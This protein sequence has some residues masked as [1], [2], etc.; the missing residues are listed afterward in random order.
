MQ[1]DKRKNKAIKILKKEGL[2]NLEYLGQGFEGVVFHDEQYIYKLIL[3]FYH[4]ENKWSF[5]NH[6]NFFFEKSEHRAFYQIEIIETKSGFLIQKYPYEKSEI[7]TKFSEQDCID[8]LTQCW[9]KRIIVQDCKKENFIRVN[10][11]LKLIDMDACVYYN[12]SL[13][14]NTCARMFLFT[15]YY[16]HPDLKKLQRSAI[17]NF[18]LS[19]LN[20]LREFVNRVFANI[21]FEESKSFRKNLKFREKHEL[22]Y[23]EYSFE[24]LPNL[25]TLFYEKIKQGLYLLDIQIDEIFLS[26]KNTFRPKT[27]FLGYKKIISRKEKISLLI[28]TCAMDAATIEENIRHIVRQLSL[29]NNFYEIV[30]SIDSKKENFLRQY[31]DTADYEK[32]IQIAQSLQKEKVIDRYII[33]NPDE[34]ENINER[35]FGIKTRE[36]HSIT[37]VPIASQLYAFEQ[38]KGQY[39][40]QMDSDVM[41]NRKDYEHNYLDDMILEFRKNEKVVSVGFNIYNS[42]T[43]PY[44]GHENGGFVPEVR[45]GLFHKK[46]F[47][48]LRPLPN[49]INNEGKLE[50]TWYRAMEKQQKATGFCSIRGGDN[51]TCYIHP[52]NYRKTMQFAWMNIEDRVEQN[53]IPQCQLNQFDCEGSF[54]EWCNPKRNE[55]IVVLSC[56][57]NITIDKFLRFWVALMSQSYKDFGLILYDDC[58][59]NGISLFIK[60]M[61]EPFKDHVTYIIGRTHLPKIQCEYIAIHNFCENPETIIVSADTDDALIGNDVLFEVYKKYKMW[62]IDLSCGRVHQTYR[63]QSTY[64]YPVNFMTPRSKGG[65]VWQHLKTF[66]KYLF[67]S[68]PIPYFKY[69]RNETKLSEIKWFEK[70]DDFAMMI[71]MVEMSSSPY[72]MDFINYYYDRDYENR[73]AERGIKEDCIAE[74]LKKKK[75]NK[76]NVVKGRKTFHSNLAKIE[77]DITF[78]CN[79]KC[80]GCNRSCGEAVS[81]EK[82]SVQDI[83]NFIRE[84]IK[85]NH[86]WDLIT[87]LGGEPTLHPEF[88]KIID[89]LQK[90]YADRFNSDVVIQ[91][92]SN[93]LTKDSR[94]LCDK[95]EAYKNVKIDRNSY[96]TNMTKKIVDYFTPFADAP[97]DDEKFK[98]ADFTKACWVTSY[99][100]I[101][102]NKNGYFACSVCGAIDRVMHKNSGFSSF[103]ELTEENQKKHFSKYC[104][105]C[106]NFKYYDSNAGDFIPRCEKAPFKETI[107]K[108]WRHIYTEYNS[109]K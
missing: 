14:Y 55:E 15:H 92:V 91:V 23:E 60:R 29:P 2:S 27:I 66:K 16:D 101:G 51:R 25:Q 88:E 49:S 106:G 82:M 43:K 70:C 76:I 71:P 83:N 103:T 61:I 108:T 97:C 93:G 75:L 24:D 80:K 32:V 9:Q 81:N 79:L 47:F 109:I 78:E 105:L 39:I 13:F 31:T 30:V 50:L 86:K 45:I 107:S 89:L 57:K 5:Y 12:D 90:A 17:N 37:N 26:E 95:V 98:N 63:I 65:N 20:G 41:I 69:D 48:N 38:C 85:N 54:Y 19:E 74:I 7:V 18:E 42:E 4:S 1:N 6:L 53:I 34:T 100:G 102:L 11:A 36:T 46:R 8:F 104:K 58:S 99:C 84:S 59:N 87:I 22:I 33:F 77:I 52:Q 3:P 62:G 44:S 94:D 56:F 96:K 73:E 67:D 72:Q 28:K 35:W 10:G 21:I 40:F 68:I 64:R